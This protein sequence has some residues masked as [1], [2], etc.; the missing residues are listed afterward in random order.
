MH[1]CEHLD[2][3]FS[4]ITLFRT[5]LG[6]RATTVWSWGGMEVQTIVA[7]S[8][9]LR[10]GSYVKD[11]AVYKKCHCHSQKNKNAQ[12]RLNLCVTPWEGQGEGGG[13]WQKKVRASL[14]SLTQKSPGA[15]ITYLHAPRQLLA[16]DY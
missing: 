1:V 2:C 4:L 7:R 8:T 14:T 11:D 12:K 3:Q 6:V 15:M 5:R 13:Q 10:V 16:V 9:R